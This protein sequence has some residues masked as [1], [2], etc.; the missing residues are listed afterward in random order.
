MIFQKVRFV[1]E[2]NIVEPEPIQQNIKIS[3]KSSQQHHLSQKQSNQQSNQQSEK[4]LNQQ[5]SFMDDTNDTNDT[6]KKQKKD[7][8]KTINKTIDKTIDKTANKTIDNHH[9]VGLIMIHSVSMQ[10]LHNMKWNCHSNMKYVNLTS[11]YCD[12]SNKFPVL[13]IENEDLKQKGF[14]Y[15]N[16]I[17]QKIHDKYGIKKDDIHLIKLYETVD[18]LHNYVIILNN[19][20]LFSQSNDTF[21]WKITWDLFQ[22]PSTISKN[23]KISQ[24]EIYRRVNTND[25]IYMDLLKKRVYLPVNSNF[26]YELNYGHLLTKLTTII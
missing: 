23:A 20:T 18:K 24:K 26:D 1:R 2:L 9:Y 22:I 17:R 15:K 8:D 4:N 3:I 7:P 12:N 5:N 6:T 11:I 21:N 19:R 25:D 14:K 16:F 13:K 10:K